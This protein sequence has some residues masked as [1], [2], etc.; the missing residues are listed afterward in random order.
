M[1][2][3]DRYSQHSSIISPVLLNSWAFVYKLSA[4]GFDLRCSHRYSTCF[5]L[6]VHWQSGNYRIWILP[7]TCTWHNKNI[8]S[9]T[10]IQTFRRFDLGAW[11][12]PEK[13]YGKVQYTK[14]FCEIFPAQ[15]H[16]PPKMVLHLCICWGHRHFKSFCQYSITYKIGFRFL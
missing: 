6:G 7:E 2:R 14:K 4:C 12:T 9:S 5:E 13:I 8:P 10:N 11:Q 16:F 15:S 3:T 1:H